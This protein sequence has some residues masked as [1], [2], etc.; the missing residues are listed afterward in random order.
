MWARPAWWGPRGCSLAGSPAAASRGRVCEIPI[1]SGSKSA[2]SGPLNR[3]MSLRS[4]NGQGAGT[5]LRE[6]R[7]GFILTVRSQA[8]R[9]RGACGA[10]WAAWFWLKGTSPE[11]GGWGRGGFPSL[12]GG[13]AVIPRLTWRFRRAGSPHGSPPG[14]RRARGCGVASSW[15]CQPP[16]A[17]RGLARRVHP[18][19]R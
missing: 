14:P 11:A 19:R 16:G 7:R 12:F 10:E 3:C 9:K 2:L 8:V 6:F 1:G 15:H 4:H 13:E 5:P 17:G 18:A